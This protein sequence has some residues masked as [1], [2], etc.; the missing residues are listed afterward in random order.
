MTAPFSATRR[1]RSTLTTVSSIATRIAQALSKIYIEDLLSGTTTM[2]KAS[3]QLMGHLFQLRNQCSRGVQPAP[4]GT[5][6][7][8]VQPKQRGSRIP[9]NRRLQPEFYPATC[10]TLRRPMGSSSQLHQIPPAT[11]PRCSDCHLRRAEHLI[12]WNWGL[13]QLQTPLCLS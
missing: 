9:D 6:R 4:G 8:N 2:K 5:T 11:N 7:F 13:P 1:L 10:T 12:N 3:Q